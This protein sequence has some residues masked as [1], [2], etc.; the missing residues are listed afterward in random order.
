[1]AKASLRGKLYILLAFAMTIALEA[2]QWK[3]GFGNPSW[4]LVDT[5]RVAVTA[6]AFV[7]IYRGSEVAHWLIVFSAVLAIGVIWRL[8]PMPLPQSALWQ[9][10]FLS[11]ALLALLAPATRSHVRMKSGANLPD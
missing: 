10:S 4:G 7:M 3:V 2:L 8:N 6:I 9:I 5:A 1:M 11:V